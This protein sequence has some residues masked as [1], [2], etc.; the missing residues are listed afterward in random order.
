MAKTNTCSENSN[1]QSAILTTY[2]SSVVSDK[3]SEITDHNGIHNS[4]IRRDRNYW[5]KKT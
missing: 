5:F 4:N 1:V 3:G 2:F